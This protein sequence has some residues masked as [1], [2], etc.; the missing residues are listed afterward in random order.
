MPM[1]PLELVDSSNNHLLSGPDWGVDTLQPGACVGVFQAGATPRVPS[2]VRCSPTGKVL[3]TSTAFW[4]NPVVFKYNGTEIGTCQ[5]E[6]A[7]CA[8]NTQP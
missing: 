8:V 3:I 5:L 1:S 4:T 2:N 7:K 6:P